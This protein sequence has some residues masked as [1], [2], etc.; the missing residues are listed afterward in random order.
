MS[1]VCY[2]AAVLVGR[3]TNLVRPF[4]CLVLAGSWK[5]KRRRKTEIV[6]NMIPIPWCG[7]TGMTVKRMAAQLVGTGPTYYSSLS[8]IV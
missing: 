6:V 8:C 2:C 7:V 4:V 5:T 1:V 3:I